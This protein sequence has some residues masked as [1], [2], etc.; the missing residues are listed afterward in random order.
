MGLGRSL[1]GIQVSAGQSAAELEVGIGQDS[2]VQYVCV[3][4]LDQS[5][6]GDL[7]SGFG[8]RH[9]LVGY[10]HRVETCVLGP[11]ASFTQHR[12]PRER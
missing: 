8:G 3:G 4:E 12:L 1:G 7:G 5:G 2:V 11:Q 9:P 10:E 6:C